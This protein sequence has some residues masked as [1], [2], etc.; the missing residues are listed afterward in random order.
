M[1][2]LLTQSETGEAQT[3][4]GRTLVR[5]SIWTVAALFVAM[6]SVI[7][8]ESLYKPAQ[9]GVAQTTI[10]LVQARPEMAGAEVT[11]DEPI[12]GSQT[13][14]LG[15]ERE[16]VCVFRLAAG[17]YRVRVVK[18]G[19]LVFQSML[20]VGEYQYRILTIP[21]PESDTENAAGSS[22]EGGAAQRVRTERWSASAR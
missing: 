6:L 21:S 5:L 11:L 12:L 7:F 17:R 4:P 14:R 19:E 2:E 20:S 10:L 3:P 18:G 13:R 22:A 16:G 1:S 15:E 8:Y 9:S